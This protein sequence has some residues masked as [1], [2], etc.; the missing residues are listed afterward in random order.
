MTIIACANIGL[1]GSEC[2]P[3]DNS[4][5]NG[6]GE[7]VRAVWRNV[8]DRLMA[9][10]TKWNV[11]ADILGLQEDG[12]YN[13]MPEPFFGAPINTDFNVTY[14]TQGRGK[15]GVSAYCNL[16]NDDITAI[17]PLDNV[18]E[19]TAITFKYLNKHGKLIKA[20]YINF[21]RN[22]HKDH[23]RTVNETVN[24]IKR[25]IKHIRTN[26]NIR[27]FIVQGDFNSEERV[28]LGL[29]FREH[30]HRKLF[31]KHNA[32]TRKTKID[33]VW[34]NCKDFGILDIFN[35][36]ENKVKD[37]E[38]GTLGHKFIV[39]WVGKRPTMP[40]KETVKR[41]DF[42]LLKS[43]TR[44][45]NPAFTINDNEPLESIYDIDKALEDFMSRMNDITKKS[46]K[47]IV[48][49]V[50]RT[51]EALLNQI[52]KTEDEILTGKS[53]AQ[54]LYRSMK[55]FRK[56]IDSV[57]DN[58]K[59]T[60]DKLGKKLED[61]LDK[62]NDADHIIGKKVVKEMF[63]SIPGN[64]CRR[65]NDLDEFSKICMSTSNSG[66]VDSAGFS[67][68]ITKILLSNRQI[69]RRY[70]RI[71][72][73]CLTLGYF[74]HEWK[75]DCIHFIY[76]N[77]GS[78]TEP[79]N[80]RPITIA[81][82]F[83]KHFEKTIS[84]IIAGFN[85]LNH[86]NHSYKKGKGCLTA[87]TKAQEALLIDFIRAKG[88][89][90]RG[91]KLSTNYQFDDISGA[92][93]SVDH[94]ILEYALELIFRLEPNYNIKGVI[95]S[96][97]NRRARVVDDHSDD[98]Y[99]LKLKHL[100]SIPQGSILSPLLWRIFDGIFTQL[101]KNSFP[102]VLE[103]HSDIFAITHISYADDHLTIFTIILDCSSSDADN[104]RRISQVFDML[105]ELL[106]S[107]TRALGSD[108]NPIKSESV[109][110]K[111]LVPHIDLVNKTEKDPSNKLKWLGYHLFVN[112][113]QQLTLDEQKIKEKINE[114]NSFRY[115]V[116][117][118]TSRIGLRWRIYQVYISP[119]I[120]LFLPLVIQ[121]SNHLK[122]TIIHNLQHRS[123]CSAIGLPW[124][125][126]RRCIEIKLGEKSVEEKA[127]RMAAR[128]V[129]ANHISRP[130]FGDNVPNL[131]SGRI[132][133]NPT[134]RIERSFFIVRLFVYKNLETTCTEKVKFNSQE[135]RK[136]A[137]HIRLIVKNHQI[138]NRNTLS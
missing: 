55:F 67:L 27:N 101:Y 89:D 92:F 68:K 31:H 59:P 106:R 105:R 39:L 125:T 131:R 6:V 114:I 14:G 78:R 3:E 98:C 11:K 91:K 37:N 24:A 12:G 79:S 83:G 119:F 41:I 13:F 80:W 126:S 108:M 25:T 77:K 50:N 28:N 45:H 118:Y 35:T 64:K 109:V 75:S 90:M 49:K 136:W 56:G 46:Y 32:A 94:V 62:L 43:N 36:A 112:D 58:T 34:S 48:S 134:K 88:I 54:T 16:E 21:Y 44:G 23:E 81:S 65:W 8:Q 107:A 104:G 74:P 47:S 100:R 15:A 10:R 124:T 70:E 69:L 82:S 7:N 29:D 102:K 84:Y 63:G 132:A 87:I 93:E 73:A 86:D 61:K 127:K 19:I 42:K 57:T 40:I 71:I 128:L 96:Y 95:I 30:E 5:V 17:D 2:N 60:I 121:G 72:Q 20:A 26:H 130:F 111:N 85:D 4:D 115:K 99:E 122:I 38:D 133:S 76:K 66:A 113:D 110:T 97:L 33:R 116:F 1:R 18:N 53:Q 9:L 51:E 120:E 135:I 123:I 138:R 52:E 129:E 103:D 137:N 117:Q 22:A